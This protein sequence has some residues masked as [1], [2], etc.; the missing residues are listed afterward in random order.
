[1]RKQSN[2]IRKTNFLFKR[3]LAVSMLPVIT[4]A[5]FF[6]GIEAAYGKTVDERVNDLLAK[7]TLEEKVHQLCRKDNMSTLDNQRLGI[8]SFLF[9]DTP[10]GMN[11]GEAQHKATS[12]PVSISM[13]STWDPDLVQKIGTAIGMEARSVG[14]NQ[15]LGPCIDVA[16]DPRAGRTQECYG[17]DPYLSSKMAVAYIKGMQSTKLI[18]TAKHFNLNARENNRRY[19]DC[20]IDDRTLIEHY[21]LPFKAAVQ[22]G[23]VMCVMTGYNRINGV[24]CGYNKH[25]ITDILRNQWGYKYYTI[26]DWGSIYGARPALNAGLD[27]EMG[28]NHY[29]NIPK[30]LNRG[31]EQK[32]LDDAVK[33]VLYTKISSGILDGLPPV[34]KSYLNRKEHQNL[35]LE[36]ARKGIVLLKNEDNIL[37]LSKSSIKSIAVIG[38]NADTDGLGDHGS[39]RVTPPYTVTALQG[40]RNK[41]GEKIIINYAKGCDTFTVDGNVNGEIDRSG[42]EEAKKLAAESDVVIYVGGLDHILEGEDH[43][44]LTGSIELPGAQPDLINELAQ[45]NKNIIVVLENGGAIG[46]TK[47]EKNV[48]GIIEAWYPGME[49][50]NAL[51]EVL[52]GDY[53]PGGKLVISFPKTDAQL[54]EWNN[55]FRNDLKRGVGYRYFDK[56]SIAP[57]Y[58]FG[59]GLS[60]TSF[61][62]SGLKIRNN[63]TSSKLSV[64]VSVDVKNTGSRAGDEVVQLYV[65]DVKCSV[66]RSVKDLKGFKRVSLKPGEKKT[67]TLTLTARELSFYDEKTKKFTVEP[68][69]FKILMGNSSLNLPLTGSFKV[70][71]TFRE[72]DNSGNFKAA[73][74]VTDTDDSGK[75]T[76]GSKSSG[77]GIPAAVWY[78]I[79]ALVLAALGMAVII[80]FRIFRNSRHIVCVD[81]AGLQE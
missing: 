16:R 40:I 73:G 63:S 32:T 31:I 37:P 20:L 47:F 49:G 17:E 23:G 72:S 27:V 75:G 60:Y 48:K 6:A 79:S 58:P 7:M 36:T 70:N 65:G 3:I 15:G 11:G 51:A 53:N 28:F 80:S 45:V 68:G 13:A 29:F 1:M 24:W 9:A 21:G 77:R 57:Q 5:V 14:R 67:V 62:F 64:D 2:G 71:S 61:E 55:D 41:A 35:A 59:Y 43:D 26:S 12:F 10:H 22:E 69:E 66:P 78:G 54:P 76:G 19:N 42:F 4:A 25:L 18:A 44:R 81:K 38:P 74:I 52:F 50:G 56:Q 46:L 30:Q 33:R 8:P 34:D 39:S